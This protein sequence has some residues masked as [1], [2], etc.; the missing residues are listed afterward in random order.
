MCFSWL[1]M[2]LTTTERTDN[3][4]CFIKVSAINVIY[5][6]ITLS[7]IIIIRIVGPIIRI[8]ITHNK[9]Y[10]ALYI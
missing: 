7:V 1:D 9:L 2:S 3:K 10:C 8:I 6:R 5:I 4:S